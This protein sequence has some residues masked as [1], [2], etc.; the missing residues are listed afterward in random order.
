MNEENNCKFIGSV[1]FRKSCDIHS[2]R[3]DKGYYWLP[4]IFLTAK[5]ERMDFRK[6]MEMGAD[7]YITKP[8]EKIELLNAVEGRLKKSASLKKEFDKINELK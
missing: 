8:F 4:F 2:L 7:D 6:G 1:G 3:N 5:S